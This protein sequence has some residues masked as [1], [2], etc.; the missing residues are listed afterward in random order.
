MAV[1]PTQ[2][3]KR[4]LNA[5]QRKRARG[6]G[7]TLNA[8]KTQMTLSAVKA[9]KYFGKKRYKLLVNRAQIV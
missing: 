8:G 5:S 7:A 1:T 6:K 9:K 3:I 2:N 4:T